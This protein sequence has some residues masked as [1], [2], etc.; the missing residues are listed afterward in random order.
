MVRNQSV[1]ELIQLLNV[2]DETEDVEAKAAEDAAGKSVLETICAM[3]NE[4]DLGG[5]TILLG[6]RKQQQLFAFYEPTGVSDPDRTSSDI[7]S[8]CSSTFNVPIRIDISAVEVEGAIVL[9]IDVPELPKSQKPL[10]FRARGLPAGAFRRIGPTDVRCTDE[11][12]Q[13]FFYEKADESFDARVIHDSGWDDLDPA[14]IA[15][16]RK[17]RESLD[18]FAEELTWSDEDTMAALNATKTVDGRIR[19]TTTGLLVFGRATALRRLAPSH[20]VDYIRVPTNTWFSDPSAQFESLDMRGPMITLIS[21]VIATIA[22][23]LPRTVMIE[24][25]LSGQRN[26]IPVVPLRVIREATINALMHRNYQI[27]QPIQIIRYPNRLVIKNAGY[28]LKSED[29]FGEPG[30]ASRNPT[31]AAI[32]HDTRFAETKGSGM[33]VMQTKMKESG[34]AAP[35]FDSDRGR[36]EFSTTLLFHHFLDQAD[37]KWLASF[38][39][40]NLTEDQMKALIFVRE[41]G[42]IDNSTYRNL[43]YTDT[44]SASRSLRQLT[45]VGLLKQG[46][47]GARS[48]YDPGPELLARTP[49]GLQTESQSIQANDLSL[50]DIQDSEGLFRQLPQQLKIAVRSSHLQQRMAPDKLVAL[51][52]RLCAWRPLSAMEIAG[53]LKRNPT[54]ISQKFLTGMIREGRLVYLYPEM[55]QHPGQKYAAPVPTFGTA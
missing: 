43:T 45:K 37:W 11:D 48:Y 15:A 30:S 5:G 38:A 10:Y 36:D 41:V 21:R 35:S 52:E 23:D 31:I 44:L 28:S 19:L 2:T 29:R 4:P 9:R 8:A 24:E 7:A 12:I 25:G 50:E 47:G 54:Y 20:R 18:R 42:A 33:R 49:N 55:I 27:H 14:A 1:I 34:L 17:E 53:L 51:I 3:A 26:E 22:D 40:L 39:D 32:L 16:Y 46:G 13:A 6:V